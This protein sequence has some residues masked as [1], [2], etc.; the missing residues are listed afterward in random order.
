MV[1]ATAYRDRTL[2]TALERLAAQTR[3]PLEVVIVDGAPD[4]G[5]EQLVADQRRT[6]GLNI[7][8]LRSAPP[9]AA[10]Q[11]NVGVKA[12]SGDIIVFLDDDVY[13]EA[14]SLER[15]VQ[16]FE[17]DRDERIG[18][19]GVLIRNQL[20]LPPSKLAKRWFDFLAD[21]RRP[22]YSGMIIGPAVAI[23]PE[24]TPQAGIA[25]AQ[26]LMSTCAAYRR[27]ALP[28]GPFN[29]R[30]Q[31][32]SYMED[33]DL[34]VRVARHSELVVHTGIYV[35]HDSQ[36]SVFKRPYVRARMIVHN[37]YYVMTVTLGRRTLGHHARFL[38]S[39]AVPQ[40][41]SLRDVRRPS[42]FKIWVQS[43]S[44]TISGL[45]GLVASTD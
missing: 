5:C 38:L 8:Y 14:D 34:S 31:G 39:L 21:E 15:M 29:S 36:P 42:D 18:G 12:S 7:V 4:P 17:N 26:W 40:L 3:R 23:G 27:S 28:P 1:I 19:L 10:I 45:F 41:V 16:V 33:V 11:R 20:C 25:P 43:L 32:Y 24:P 30:F 35:F 22:S 9:S 6:S 37:R 13:L 44:G 2:A